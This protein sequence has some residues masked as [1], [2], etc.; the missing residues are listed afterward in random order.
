MIT[1]QRV[2]SSNYTNLRHRNNNRQKCT[3]TR[4]QK[5]RKTKTRGRAH[6]NQNNNNDRRGTNREDRRQTKGTPNLSGT[7]GLHKRIKV[8]SR[9]TGHTNTGRSRCSI[10]RTYRPNL[11]RDRRILPLPRYRRSSRNNRQRGMRNVSLRCQRRFSIRRATSQVSRRRC[12]NSSQ[13]GR[14][15][16]S[17]QRVNVINITNI[18]L[19]DDEYHTVLTRCHNRRC[20]RHRAARYQR[21]TTSRRLKELRTRP[22]DHNSNIQIKERSITHL[23]STER[24][25][26]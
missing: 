2:V 16:T 7:S 26:R 19:N 11:N 10:N 9:P 21:S 24:N 8:H 6:K 17:Q 18:R 12:R 1:I 4:G 3:G 22:K 15:T 25:R 5:S 20:N 14:D 23:T 13:N